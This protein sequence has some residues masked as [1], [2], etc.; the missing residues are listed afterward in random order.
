M[1]AYFV[2][3]LFYVA[4]FP[5]GG[6]QIKEERNKITVQIVFIESVLRV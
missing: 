2:A 5:V 6:E 1:L 4:Y 3:T